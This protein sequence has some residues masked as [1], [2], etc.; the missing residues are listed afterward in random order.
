[1]GSRN[2]ANHTL[3]K[4]KDVPIVVSIGTSF[5]MSATVATYH[6]SKTVMRLSRRVTL[7][8]LAPSRSD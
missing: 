8:M 2:T 5:T 1:M 3:Q 7:R 6:H 4:Q